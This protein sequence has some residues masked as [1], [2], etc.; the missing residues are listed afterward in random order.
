[1]AKRVLG[2]S[3]MCFTKEKSNEIIVT[4]FWSC[5]VLIMLIVMLAWATKK[6]LLGSRVK[7]WWGMC[8]NHIIEEFI[9]DRDELFRQV[10]ME[11]LVIM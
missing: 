3:F 8:H 1:M 11:E 4:I 7:L 9:E 2:A 5:M 10:R 6:M